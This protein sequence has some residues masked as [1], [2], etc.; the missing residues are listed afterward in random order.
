MKL[1]SPGALVAAGLLFGACGQE[2]PVHDGVLLTAF[3]QAG[4]EGVLLNEPWVMHFSAELDPASVTRASARVVDEAGRSIAGHFEVHEAQLVF[5]P[6][7]AMRGD[8]SDGGL[9]PGERVDVELLGYPAP[10][11]VR[12]RNGTLL[13]QSFQTSFRVVTEQRVQF[14]DESPDGAAPLVLESY[15]VGTS[16]PLQLTCDE[17]LDPRSLSSDAFE[18]KRFR[19]GTPPGGDGEGNGWFEVIPLEAVLIANTKEGARIEL[20]AMDSTDG[21]LTPRTL[22]PGEYHLWVPEGAAAPLDLGG[23]PVRSAWALSQLPAT[24]SVVVRADEGGSRVHREEFLSRALRS[25]AE[26]PGM[27]GTATWDGDGVVTVRLPLA[28]GDGTAGTVVL[29]GDST[30]LRAARGD[31]HAA[32]LLVPAGVRLDLSD[33]DGP[34]VLRAQGSLRID[35]DLFRSVEQGAAAR[36]PEESWGAWYGRSGK[37]D[38]PKLTA[39]MGYAGIGGLEDW[40]KAAKLRGES[41]TV[42]VAGGDL[43]IDGSITVDGPLLLAAGGRM[44]F[45]GDVEAREILTVGEGGGVSVN[46][47]PRRPELAFQR[48]ASNPLTAPLRVGV[49]SAPFRPGGGDL[50]WRSALVG[51]RP[52]SGRVDLRFLGERPGPDG[53]IET[54]GPVEDASLLDRCDAIRL[55]IEL[56]IGPGKSW[57]PP[58]VDF[59]DLRW[60]EEAGQ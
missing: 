8:L 14:L 44:R 58:M 34:V 51:A 33:L 38:V 40:I 3:R 45:S 52:G 50:R 15:E 32:S 10:S 55:W 20:R 23:H 22:E 54:V 9:R 59:V 36:D 25:P 12:S 11:G 7:L 47:A 30:P 1:L 29:A 4:Q 6:R 26:V 53:R 2:A 60:I 48:P 21:A 49:L 28:A 41:W 43:F 42:L 13:A 31:L 16:E 19:A 17:P 27:D 5:H 18:L 35:G 56:E 39:P 24:L 57:D 37:D 46:P